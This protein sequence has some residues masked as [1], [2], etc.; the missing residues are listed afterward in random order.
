M[1][2]ME[3]GT[4]SVPRNEMIN[5]VNQFDWLRKCMESVLTLSPLSHSNP[6]NKTKLLH[7]RKLLGTITKTNL[8]KQIM[9]YIF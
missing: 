1:R 3:I 7:A 6:K 5:P 9:Q 2:E 4:L 8:C